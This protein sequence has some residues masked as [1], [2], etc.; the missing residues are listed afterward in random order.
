[1]QAIAYPIL[2]MRLS[3]KLLIQDHSQIFYLI[4][5]T[6]L[7]LKK[8]R[9][10]RTPNLFGICEK[11]DCGFV[12]IYRQII[13]QQF[14]TQFKI[15]CIRT[16]TGYLRTYLFA[17]GGLVTHLQFKKGV[18]I[19]VYEEYDWSFADDKVENYYECCPRELTLNFSKLSPRRSHLPCLYIFR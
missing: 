16:Q 4:Y 18:A 2:K 10:L 14:S 19:A 1:M 15:P 12:C 6:Q 3:I 7:S 9:I 17:W 11:D 8:F 13:V 5:Y